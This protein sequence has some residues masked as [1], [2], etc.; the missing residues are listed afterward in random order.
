MFLPSGGYTDLDK[1]RGERSR[2]LCKKRHQRHK[3]RLGWR[4]EGHGLLWAKW[5]ALLFWQQK[6]P[7]LCHRDFP[8]SSA[9]DQGQASWFPG[10]LGLAKNGFLQSQKIKTESRQG[11]WEL[12]PWNSPFFVSQ[13]SLLALVPFHTCHVHSAGTWGGEGVTPGLHPRA[14]LQLPSL[15][16]LPWPGVAWIWPKLYR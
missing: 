8:P 1:V 9:Y 6:D 14:L 15:P 10:P 7:G 2:G 4:R 11:G 16:E 13:V 3:A 5:G 12:G